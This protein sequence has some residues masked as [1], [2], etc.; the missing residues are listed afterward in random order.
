MLFRSVT[1]VGPRGT[2]KKTFKHANLEIEMSEDSKTMRVDA[3]FANRKEL[4][5]VRTVCSHVKN[6][7]T[8]V[9]LGYLY[10]LRLVY[11]HFPI[12]TVVADGG[13]KIEIRNFLGEK[14]T[15]VVKAYPGAKISLSKDVKEEILVEAND[16]HLAD[17]ARRLHRVIDQRRLVAPQAGQ[18]R[19]VGIFD[20]HVLHVRLRLQHGTAGGLRARLDVHSP[21]AGHRHTA[22]IGSGASS[23]DAMEGKACREQQRQRHQRHHQQ[24]RVVP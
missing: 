6:M 12:N 2:L 7:M 10:K 11:A 24:T 23:C 3:W 18:Q 4:A 17:L 21:R 16:L 1:V 22:A 5:V 15:R 9:T 14:I 8:G 19:N 13:K 20:E